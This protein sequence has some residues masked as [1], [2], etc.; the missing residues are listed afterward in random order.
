M[1]VL[2]LT[3]SEVHDLLDMRGCIDVMA[4]ALSDLERGR[5]E[6]PLRIAF[7]PKNAAGGVLTW[8]PAH[9]SGPNAVYGMKI[10]CLVP[11]NPARGL[12]FHQG[13]VVLLDGETGQL[14]A[15]MNSSAVTAIRTAAVSGV[16]T[17]SLAREDARELAIIGAG[18]QARTHLEAML[19]VRPIQRV[20]IVSRTTQSAK[21]FVEWASTRFGVTIRVADSVESAV[22][23][24]DIVVTVTTAHEPVLF[25]RWL[26]PGTHVNAV[27]ASNPKH[28]EID[29][30]VVA[31]ASLF[32]DRRESL[33]SE[34]ADFRAALEQ[35]L[36]S[37]DHLRGELGQVLT[38]AI[39]G[40][41]SPGEIT[42]FRSL[43]LASEDVAAGYYL[44]QKARSQGAGTIAEY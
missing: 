31:A 32:T 34:A 23:S 10:A 7:A 14:R 20:Q 11:S 28:C 8:M 21:R 25:G 44:L 41:Q 35:G 19:C 13:A 33:F 16:A 22:Q 3:A 43:G 42:L 5:F 6:Q 27:G 12:D 26:A 40:R 24:A 15:V 29:K 17:R 2:L 38:G 30:T 1:A 18:I 9:R 36:V 37:S 4:D 39:P